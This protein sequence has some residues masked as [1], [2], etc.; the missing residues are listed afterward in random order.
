[1]SYT[2]GP[3]RNA[4]SLSKLDPFSSA[5]G[6]CTLK[7]FTQT[8]TLYHIDAILGCNQSSGFNVNPSYLCDSDVSMT[9]AASSWQSSLQDSHQMH[10]EFIVLCCCQCGSTKRLKFSLL[11]LQPTGRTL[12]FLH[13]GRSRDRYSPRQRVY[14][15]LLHQPLDQ[16]PMPQTPKNQSE[17]GRNLSVIMFREPLPQRTV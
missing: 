10:C 2:V 16:C 7:F 11:C 13:G 15:T 4:T 6:F 9:V 14:P 5:Y 8:C 3:G 1:M 17:T 12:L